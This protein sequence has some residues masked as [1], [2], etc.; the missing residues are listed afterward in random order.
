[1]A[2]V[3]KVLDGDT[4]QLESGEYI[5]LAGVKA[6]E[7][8]QKEFDRAKEALKSLIEDK[9]VAIERV[10]TSYGRTVAEVKIKGKSVNLSMKR[11]GYINKGK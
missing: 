8:E 10:G 9:N 4:F 11:R 7:R 5:R 6:P 2:K 3:K 1:M